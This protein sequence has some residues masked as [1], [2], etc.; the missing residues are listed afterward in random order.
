[1]WEEEDVA[2]F[3]QE[4]KILKILKILHLHSFSKVTVPGQPEPHG[5]GESGLEEKTWGSGGP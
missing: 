2:K 5:S 4:E 3:V 1:M